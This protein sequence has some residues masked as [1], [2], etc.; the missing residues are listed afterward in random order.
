MLFSVYY[1]CTWYRKTENISKILSSFFFYTNRFAEL[2]RIISTHRHTRLLACFRFST[3][4]TEEKEKKRK[5]M[6]CRRRYCLLLLL[7]RTSERTGRVQQR[8]EKL[9]RLAAVTEGEKVCVY[10][11]VAIG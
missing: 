4:K 8:R 11:V 2:V 3:K 7:G 6:M 9:G 10:V 5:T 1:V